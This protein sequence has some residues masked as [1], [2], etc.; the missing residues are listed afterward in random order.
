MTETPTSENGSKQ[1]KDEPAYIDLE[2][3][4][5]EL[6][7]RV[8]VEYTGDVANMPDDKLIEAIGAISTAVIALEL[9]H[10][11]TH[12]HEFMDMP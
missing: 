8:F 10:L 2:A 4:V 5:T 12:V 6:D 1:A 11:H 9:R 3:M 7:R